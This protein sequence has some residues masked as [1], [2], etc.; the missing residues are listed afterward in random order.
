[1]ESNRRMS[2]KTV[3][4]RRGFG[5]IGAVPEHVIIDG[6]NL[7]FAMYEHAPVP[8]IGRETLVRTV[9]RWA[10]TGRADVSLIFDGGVP[11]GGLAEQMRSDRIDVQ[12]SA[13]ATADDVIVAMVH[14]SRDPG[15]IRVVSS[16]K[17]VGAEARR[18][19]CRHTTSVAFVA[20]MFPPKSRPPSPEVSSTGNDKP[21]E[22]G[23][24]QR[25]LET[26]GIDNPNNES[27][28]GDDAMTH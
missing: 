1:M 24:T 8:N 6:N 9:E 7:L 22:M 12:F 5:D 10:R 17:A 2:P 27:F 18:R 19:R 20:E 16:D 3:A 21:E 26:F 4:L 25:W 15:A 13:P 14:E 28:D 23:D 11:R